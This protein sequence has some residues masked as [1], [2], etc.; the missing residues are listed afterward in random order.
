MKSM[1]YND[2]NIVL[3]V[4]LMFLTSCSMTTLKHGRD[5]R[6]VRNSNLISKCSF[7]DVI[8]HINEMELMFR[9]TEIHAINSTITKIEKMGGDTMYV[10]GELRHGVQVNVYKCKN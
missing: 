6:I 8:T 1:R 3:F 9:D 10:T 2:I 5:V 4:T 7:I